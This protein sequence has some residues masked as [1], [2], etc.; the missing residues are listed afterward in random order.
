MTHEKDFNIRLPSNI[1]I[2]EGAI[3]NYKESTN[4]RGSPKSESL[5]KKLNIRK[6]A[7][8]GTTYNFEY[9]K[10][11][12]KIIFPPFLT[13]EYTYY[14]HIFGTPNEVGP[15]ASLTRIYLDNPKKEVFIDD[16]LF[17]KY[18]INDEVLWGSSICY[19]PWKREMQIGK[20]TILNE[21]YRTRQYSLN[22]ESIDVRDK[23]SL[24]ELKLNKDSKIPN[25]LKEIGLFLIGSE[26]LD[27]LLEKI[28]HYKA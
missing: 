19:E 15:S 27:E 2:F 18:K 14:V 7:S 5:F 3:K 26:N 8:S 28:Q 25:Q 24:K 10:G 20:G 17:F 22:D 16:N 12:D 11:I 6:N 1:Q 21:G 4:Y 23:Y 9:L 13:G